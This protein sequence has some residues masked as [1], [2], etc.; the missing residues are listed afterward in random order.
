M[1]ALSYTFIMKVIIVLT[2]LKG[3][4]LVYYESYKKV[5]VPFSTLK[6]IRNHHKTGDK[7]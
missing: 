7:F 3:H 1:G 4:S 2:I 6:R 5:F